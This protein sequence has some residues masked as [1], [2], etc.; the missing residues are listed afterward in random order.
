MAWLARAQSPDGR[1]DGSAYDA[2]RGPNDQTL[3][4]VDG[5]RSKLR[6]GR[7]AD[8]GLTGLATLSFLGAGYTRAAGRYA[9]VV[10]RA[11]RFLLD[12]QAEDGDLGG[13]ANYFARMYCHGIA[14]Y[15]L[16]E[17]L[18]LEGDRPDPALKRAV[19]RAV[20]FTAAQQYPDGGWRYSQRAPYGDVSMFGW[21]CLALKSAANAGVAMPGRSRA[22]MIEFLRS[23]SETDPREGEVN[24]K[25]DGGL[26]RYILYL[27]EFDRPAE[28]QTHEVDPTMTA[29]ALFCKQMLGLYRDNPAS[30]EAVA[31]LKNYPPELREWNLYYWYYA[32]LALFQH[33]GPAWEAWN[34]RLREL[35]VAEQIARGPDA[36]SWPVRGNRNNYTEFG[37]RVYST[38]LATLC[39]E[40][41]YRFTPAA[42]GAA[43]MDGRAE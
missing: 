43:A 3:A 32:T 7:R 22:K 31:Y 6:T 39:L 42:G 5:D 8:T 18:A 24:L 2:G 12:Q 17:A 21:Q 27:D 35:L 26:A 33:G 9:P 11:V 34:G 16:A 14:A 37:G 28:I 41:Y 25:P 40:V 15:A 10:D 36:G 30:V 1:W 19:E 20:A 29:E 4:D 38:A 23:R 13:D